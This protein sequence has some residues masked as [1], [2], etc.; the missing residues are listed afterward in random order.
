MSGNWDKSLVWGPPCFDSKLSVLHSVTLGTSS[1]FMTTYQNTG[2]IGQNGRQFRTVCPTYKLLTY[3]ESCEAVLHS[4]TRCS[5]SKMNVLAVAGRQTAYDVLMHKFK[6][7]HLLL[8]P[9]SSAKHTC[10][11]SSS[12]FWSFQLRH[13]HGNE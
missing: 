13:Q 10:F 1:E 11:S 2:N 9:L 4:F 12:S 5:L 6:Q 3:L 8:I 7:S